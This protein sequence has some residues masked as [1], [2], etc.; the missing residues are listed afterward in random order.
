MAR[1]DIFFPL[2][3]EIDFCLEFVRSRNQEVDNGTPH[4]EGLRGAISN[5]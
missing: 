4:S 5:Q 3:K 2:E 1:V